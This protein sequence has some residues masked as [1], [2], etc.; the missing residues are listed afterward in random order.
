MISWSWE[1]LTEIYKIPK[2]RLYISYFGGDEKKG[3]AA[4]DEAKQLWLD[5]GL[6]SLWGVSLDMGG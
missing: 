6:V 5:L 4:D 3:L 1:L 2:D